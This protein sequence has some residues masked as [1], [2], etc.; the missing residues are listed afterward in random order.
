MRPRRL[1]ALPA[2]SPAVYLRRPRPPSFPLAERGATVYARARHGL[3]HGVRAL[4][5]VPGDAV[6]APSYHH[7]S[8]IEALLRAGLELRFYEA[9]PSL[10]PDEAELES[11]LDPTVRALYLVHTLGFPV[12]AEHWRSWADRR[13]LLLLEDAAQ[14]WPARTGAT[15]AGAV[16]DLAIFCLYKTLPVPD[17][18]V[19]LL[20]RGHA[21][22]PEARRRRSAKAI[23]RSHAHWLAS[24]SGLA[25]ALGKA[26]RPHAA[27]QSEKDFD[28]GDAGTPP[29]ALTLRILARL[30]PEEAATR[31]REH[32]QILLER[33]G[34]L[35]AAPFDVLPDGASPFAF[36]V[37]VD[38][39]GGLLR[40][41][42]AERIVAIDFWAVPHPALPVDAFPGA[43]GRRARTI[44]LPVHQDLN[45]RDLR[46]IADVV[47]HEL[48]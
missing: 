19:L 1:A 9:T 30:D 13:G 28:L 24:R 38:D 47:L 27:Y 35:V 14:A 42:D 34:H 41:L 48:A 44:A 39:K 21:P 45:A 23:L 8:E 3:W 6:L 40:R 5:L 22:P 12:R 2:L 29:H 10:E 7:G 20:R 36:P 37:A 43:Q 32:Y 25:A 11:L 16:G 33:L 46:R 18:G 4:G 31:R 26:R 17:G 15:A